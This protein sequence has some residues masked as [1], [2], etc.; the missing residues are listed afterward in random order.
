MTFVQVESTMP[1][2]GSV[3]MSAETISSSAKSTIPLRCPSAA[4]F[5]TP[6][7]FSALTSDVNRMHRSE[8]DPSGTG[9]RTAMISIFPLRC[10]K[11]GI[12]AFAAPEVLGISE[13]AAARPRRLSPTGVSTT[14]WV[15]VYAW[16][17]VAMK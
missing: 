5:R 6:L 10:G 14:D 15:A 11:S 7:I 4:F 8:S 17:V 12:I 9:A 3:T 13:S 16:I 1:E 2:W